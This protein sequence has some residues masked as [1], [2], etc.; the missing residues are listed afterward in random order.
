[1]PADA[2]A[3]PPRETVPPSSGPPLRGPA[4]VT[5]DWADVA[6]LHWPV[7]TAA[8]AALL[9]RGT[10]PDLFDGVAYAGIVAFRVTSNAMAGLLPLG[11]FAELNVRLYSRDRHGRQ[12]TV[13]LSMDADSPHVVAGARLLTQ[14][15][16]MLADV[17]ITDRADGIRYVSRRRLP[18]PRV[19]AAFRVNPD[20]PVHRGSPLDDFLTARWGLHVAHVTGTRW[21]AVDHEPWP[22]HRAELV[23]PGRD[24]KTAIPVLR[25]AGL[26]V[27]AEPP[28]SV[29]WSPGVRARFGDPGGVA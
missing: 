28:C 8:V 13:F 18:G 4:L 17:R 29:L 11:G 25:A 27:E 12:G 16:Y 21:L 24:G 10:E 14:L 26:P 15:P 1:M 6:F 23:G 7:P 3:D 9:P 19:T 22:L 5:Q 20:E 2:S